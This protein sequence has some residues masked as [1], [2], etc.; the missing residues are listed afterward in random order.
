MKACYTNNFSVLCSLPAVRIV[1][2][3]GMADS[4][5]AQQ[6]ERIL[7]LGRWRDAGNTLAVG[8]DGQIFV[9]TEIEEIE[10]GNSRQGSAAGQGSARWQGTAGR[11]GATPDPEPAGSYRGQPLIERYLR[12]RPEILLYYPQARFQT[13][14]GGLWIMTQICP[15]GR[16]GP[17]FWVCL[18]LPDNLVFGPKAFAFAEIGKS[19]RPVGPRHTNFPDGSICALT[20]D[21]DAWRPND[22]PLVLLNLYAQWLVGQLFLEIEGY[23]PGPQVGLSAVYRSVEF[24]PPEWC[25][26]GGEKRYGECHSGADLVE[27]A[28]SKL[29]GKYEPLAA[30][31]VPDPIIAFARSGWRSP[32]PQGYML[33]QPY[34]GK[35]PRHTQFNNGTGTAPPRAPALRPC[36]SP[37]TPA[38]VR[39]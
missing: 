11:Q 33:T 21:D 19:P 35:E 12:F 10:D 27:V 25:H 18:F 6:K 30:R 28:I 34:L 38:D 39:G 24:L 31:S 14:E 37:D 2:K 9:H 29:Q 17:L 8:L 3:R 20:D 36:P 26:C 4:F 32:P 7:S 23:W 5:T 1:V 13:V 15:I 16:G 22:S